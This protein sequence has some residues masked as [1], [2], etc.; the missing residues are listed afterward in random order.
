MVDTTQRMTQVARSLNAVASVGEERAAL[1]SAR[2]T[3]DYGGQLVPSLSRWASPTPD[4]ASND[5]A[6]L[7]GAIDGEDRL[8]SS[9]ADT[10]PLDP[11]SWARARRQIERA[12]I[13]VAG[14]EGAA[15]A[16]ADVDVVAILGDAVA[17]APKVFLGVVGDVAGTVLNTAGQA[18]GAAGKGFFGALGVP[19]VIA[20]IVI[21]LLVLRGRG[22]V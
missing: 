22:V 5:L 8:L 7:R 12:Y 16:A 18:A 19:G 17:N 4:E 1:A 13:D 21:A 9:M 14:I 15:G 3:L 6:T 20:L 11:D 2:A 10:Q